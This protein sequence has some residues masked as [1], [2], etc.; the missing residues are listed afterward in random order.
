MLFNIADKFDQRPSIIHI[1]PQ[2]DNIYLPIQIEIIV[3]QIAKAGSDY[4]FQLIIID[5]ILGI[6]VSVR[7]PGFDFDEMDDRVF[8]GDDVDFAFADA[9][10]P[11]A[12]GVASAHEIVCRY[13]FT[14]LSKL[15]FR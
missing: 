12:D 13:F 2:A 8:F 15:K 7:C 5:G 10:I 3:L 6:A 4:F 11:L 14:Q 9:E 1:K